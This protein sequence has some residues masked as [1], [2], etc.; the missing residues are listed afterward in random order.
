MLEKMRQLAREKD[1]CVLATV[2]GGKPHCSLMAYVVDDTCREMYMVTHKQSTKYRN[3]LEN[4]A[5]SVLIDTR[6]EHAGPLRLE[7]QAM[8]VE[9]MF[10]EPKDE[11][12]RGR[13]RAQLL[14][15]HPHLKDFLNHPDAALFCIKIG[16]FLLLDGLTEAYFEKI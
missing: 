11:S 3:L 2:S 12:K 9:G 7:A 15:R 1:I 13:I 4:P 5:V 8:T 14:E 16:S 6:E 10:Q